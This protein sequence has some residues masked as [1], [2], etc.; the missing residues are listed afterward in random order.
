[1]KKI[2]ILGGFGFMGKNLNAI[3]STDPNYEI[4]NE[5][6]RTDCDMN[7]L[8]KLRDKLEDIKPDIIINAAAHVGSLGH[9]SKY[10]A[11]VIYENSVMYLTLYKAV[12]RMS[13]KEVVVINPLSNCSYPSHINIQNEEE[14]W[15]GAMHESVKNFGITK[16]LAYELSQSF[17]KQYGVKSVNLILP[18]SY[19]ENDYLDSDKTHAMNGIIMRMITS[20]RNNNSNFVV[21]GTGTPIREWIYMPDACRII[22]RIIDTENYTIPNP[23]N[24]GQEKGLSI[25]EIVSYIKYLMGYNVDIVY[26][27]TKQDGAPNKI[28]GNK[29]FRTYFPDFK[30]TDYETGINNTIKYYKNLI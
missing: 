21:W 20:M 4:F 27:T 12:S 13:K 30:Y 24:L 5:S 1:M 18:N 19:G 26:D 15:N 14:W 16:K 25:I 8:W 9:L 6:R 3:F 28:L 23:L 11:D 2:L 17:G 10:T 22:K 7:V 29:Q